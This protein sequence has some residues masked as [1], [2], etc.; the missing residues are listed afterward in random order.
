MDNDFIK[1]FLEK[2]VAEAGLDQMS[3][4][5]KAQYMGK[6]EETLNQQLGLILLQNLDEAKQQEFQAM[7]DSKT[8]DNAKIQKLADQI[9]DFD[10]KIKDGLLAFANDFIT[11]AQKNKP[12]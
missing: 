4:E 12:A 2:L 10:Q 7:I 3:P 1:S 9:P 11:L 5:F 8:L 6:L